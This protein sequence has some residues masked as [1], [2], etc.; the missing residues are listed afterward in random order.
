M[1]KGRTSRLVPLDTLRGLLIVLMIVEHARQILGGG[2]L[3]ETPDNPIP[4]LS[5]N[6]ASLIRLASHLCAPG[7][8]FLLGIGM[9]LKLAQHTTTLREARWRFF[10]R[11]ALLILLQVTVE[12]LGWGLPIL[13]RAGSEGYTG[14][15]YLG[16]LFTLG[17]SLIVTAAPLHLSSAGLLVLA[18]GMI[19][20]S[21]CPFPPALHPWAG[22][23]TSGFFGTSVEILYPVLPWSGITLLGVLFARHSL[24]NRQ[25]HPALFRLPALAA[26]IAATL[27]TLG[28]LTVGGEALAGWYK[29]PPS[30]SFVL[31]TLAIL[32]LLLTLFA[33]IPATN[34]R[35]LK[36]LGRHALV[37]YLA[38]LY[39]LGIASLLVY[40]PSMTQTLAIAAGIGLLGVV[41]CRWRERSASPNP[42]ENCFD[43]CYRFYDPFIRRSGLARTAEIRR[44]LAGVSAQ[45]D[46]LDVGGGTGYLASQ[47]AD[48]FSSI[49][50]VDSSAGMLSVAAQRKLQTCRASALALPFGPEQFDV[51]LCSDAL[52]HIKQAERALA[53]MV[54]V[55]K[56]GGTIVILEFQIRG[57]SGWLLFAFERLLL[58]RSEFL[59]PDRL[60]ALLARHGMKGS[61][62]RVS[63][64][65]YI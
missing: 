53:E 47:L 2:V 31:G 23:L 26:L 56:P 22:W 41:W 13:W 17:A 63:Y 19:A 48:L 34:L 54:R 50:V 9:A 45:G 60:Q 11:G 25:F 18:V 37:I 43:R 29:Y 33:A 12:N 4:A 40:R 51:V 46:L 61:T 30:P 42:T 55:L 14:P 52:H 38:H 57:P 27:W 6:A 21:A 3:L 5:A 35:P 49:V 15:L 65:Q 64:L 36:L 62:H 32:M 59:S 1:S 58:D 39:L 10:K 44:A 8:F 7:F 24:C 16:V 28:C 20:S